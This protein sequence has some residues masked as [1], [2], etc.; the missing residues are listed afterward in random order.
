M[1][2]K[3]PF[4]VVEMCPGPHGACFVALLVR[5]RP[6]GAAGVALAVLLPLALDIY[7]QQ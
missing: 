1:S 4:R 2:D 5:V 7:S 3:S 6:E